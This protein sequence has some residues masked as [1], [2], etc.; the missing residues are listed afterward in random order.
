MTKTLL[1]PDEYIDSEDGLIHC[2]KCHQPRQRLVFMF[3]HEIHPWIPC[4]CQEG[5]LKEEQKIRD[6][7]E[8]ERFI[9]YLKSDGLGWKALEDCRFDNMQ[10]TNPELKHKLKNYIRF[11]QEPVP[12]GLLLWGPTGRGK[13]FAAAC[14]VNDVIESGQPAVMVSF[15]QLLQELTTMPFQERKE[16]LDSIFSKSLVC[17]DDF[18]LRFLNK[19]Y[20]PLAVEVMK[21]VDHCNKPVLITTNYTLKE[22]KD[23]K[24]E[25]E[26]KLFPIVLNRVAILIDGEDL[27]RQTQKDR[28]RQLQ[29][30][31]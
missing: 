16:R 17:L 25:L 23:P 20:I 4:N 8:R 18:D 1:Q 19:L 5:E 6:I 11:I 31:M 29:T 9:R 24:N 7:A 21:R 3:G 12:C 27:G 14:I 15:T 28:V 30:T 2:K 13:T 22:L 10:D 26:G